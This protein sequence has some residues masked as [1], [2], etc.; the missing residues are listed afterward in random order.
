MGFFR[1]TNTPSIDIIG[2]KNYVAVSL[3]T[4]PARIEKVWMVIESL[5]RQSMKPDRILLFLSKEDFPLGVKSLPSSLLRLQRCGL[6]IFFVDGNLR[7]H[8]KYYYSFQDID[9]D[10]VITVDDDIIYPYNMIESLWRAHLKYPHMVIARYGKSI[11]FSCGAINPYS[12][13]ERVEKNPSAGISFGSGGGTLFP[14]RL[15]NE[16]ILK[17]DIFMRICPYAD[18]LWLLT[19]V[20]ISGLLIYLLDSKSCSILNLQIKHD[21]RLSTLNCGEDRNDK[22]MEDILTYI[23][24]KYGLTAS[25]FKD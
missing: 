1:L 23:K 3:T 11:T 18:D 2:N 22:Q 9:N 25:I 5:L 6:E 8:K 13:W 24:D 14:V 20:R 17:S 19:Y 15:I 12:R 10:Y 21:S 16:D 4:F 7:S